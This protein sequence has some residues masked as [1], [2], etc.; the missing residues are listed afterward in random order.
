MNAPSSE[1]GTLQP[2]VFHSTR[3]NAGDVK[4]A[5]AVAARVS[6]RHSYASAVASSRMRGLSEGGDSS[7]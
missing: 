2:H 4:I 3:K 5:T 7:A 6:F 1:A